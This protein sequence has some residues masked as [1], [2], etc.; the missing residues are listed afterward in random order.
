MTSLY[1]AALII[2]CGSCRGTA[3]GIACPALRCHDR[4]LHF[5]ARMCEAAPAQS[6]P[7]G[8]IVLPP[9]IRQDLA[10]S[11]TATTITKSP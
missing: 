6:Q 5:D 11:P 4:I 1:R 9:A 10:W 7:I 8:E 3:Y 2:H